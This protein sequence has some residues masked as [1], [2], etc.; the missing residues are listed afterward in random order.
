[1]DK[2]EQLIR[3]LKYSLSLVVGFDVAEVR[4]TKVSDVSIFI[5]WC[6]VVLGVGIEMSTGGFAVASKDILTLFMNMKTM[7]SGS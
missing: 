2:G 5:C 6:S 7:L 1:M 4:Q 3:Y